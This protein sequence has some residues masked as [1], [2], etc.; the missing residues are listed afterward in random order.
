[1]CI[2][3]MNMYI[4]QAACK[5]NI[6]FRLHCIRKSIKF[7]CMTEQKLMQ[8][9]RNEIKGYIHMKGMTYEKVARL[10]TQKF[11]KNVTAQSLNN[12]IA[13]GSIRYIDILQ[14]CE[15]LGYKIKWE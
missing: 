8:Q 10:L 7:Y 9:I 3:Y 6:A 12:K 15:V 11:G 2:L 13:R 1:M 14:I 4:K 5:I